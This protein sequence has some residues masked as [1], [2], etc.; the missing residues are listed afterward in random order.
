MNS[1]DI[2]I[3]KYKINKTWLA[4]T[5]GLSY[6][7]FL[8]ALERGLREDEILA[9]ETSL[10]ALGKELRSFSVPKEYRKQKID[11]DKL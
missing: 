6:H 1:L 5:V 10:H 3:K 11:L 9:L 2:L 7:A 4:S 8:Y